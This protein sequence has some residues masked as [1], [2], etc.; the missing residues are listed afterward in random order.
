MSAGTHELKDV[1]PVLTYR[2]LEAGP[3]VL[4]TTALDGRANIMTMRFHM[5]VRHAPPL[6]GVVIGPWDHSRAALV[7][8]RTV[9]VR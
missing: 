4:V 9:L 8:T 7:R 2:F 3:I 5:V 6:I 1:D